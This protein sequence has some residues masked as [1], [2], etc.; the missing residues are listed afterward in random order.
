MLF[1]VYTAVNMKNV[2]S[3]DIRTQFI[4]HEKNTTPQIQT[5]AG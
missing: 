3:W 4:P 1:E 2:V 5:T